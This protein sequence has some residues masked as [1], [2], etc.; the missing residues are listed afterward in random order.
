MAVV[1]RV[2][3]L[4]RILFPLDHL[5]RLDIP[6]TA[7]VSAVQTRKKN[8][9]Q[10]GPPAIESPAHL[11]K[12]FF[13]DFRAPCR[14][15]PSRPCSPSPR[16]RRLPSITTVIPLRIPCFF[17]CTADTLPRQV[18]QIT[19]SPTVASRRR[20]EP[21]PTTHPHR[22]LRRSGLPAARRAGHH[23]ASPLG[24]AGEPGR[25]LTRPSDRVLTCFCVF[26]FQRTTP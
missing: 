6:V 11:P 12:F 24:A 1:V 25:L 4:L 22:A 7:R 26:V 19:N 20:G 10:P 18:I 23:L 2:P 17:D 5:D 14:P 16:P 13:A 8:L 9:D 15:R 21:L 3:P